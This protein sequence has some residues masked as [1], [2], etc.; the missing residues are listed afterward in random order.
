[1]TAVER[2]GGPVPKDDGGEPSGRP[3]RGARSPRV[4]R[5]FLVV[6]LLAAG[7][8][9]QEPS[10]APACR[11]RHGLVVQPAQ[12]RAPVEPEPIDVDGQPEPIDAV[13]EYFN[14]QSEPIFGGGQREPLTDERACAAI[15]R[16][17]DGATLRRRYPDF[18]EHHLF[19]RQLRSRFEFISIDVDEW[20]ILVD[21]KKHARAH[22]QQDLFGPGGRWNAEWREWLLRFRATFGRDPAI[23]DALQKAA[24]MIETYHLEPYGLLA[25]YGCGRVIAHDLY[26]IV[27]PSEQ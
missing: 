6:A 18:Q 10:A 4:I 24:E 8:A 7:C 1:M 15:D 14:G 26:D 22:D 12:F 21:P 2:H 23:W 19:P 17:I 9:H 27:E 13:E 3:V 5:Q 20:A 25:P 16:I 11:P